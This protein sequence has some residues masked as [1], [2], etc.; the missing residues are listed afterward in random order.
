MPGLDSFV[1]KVIP[2]ST[3]M[4]AAYQHNGLMVLF[5]ATTGL[6]EAL[7][8]DN[9]YLTDVRTAAAGAVAANI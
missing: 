9:G 7:L 5:S 4:R 1:I 8:L 6:V 3:A 2:A